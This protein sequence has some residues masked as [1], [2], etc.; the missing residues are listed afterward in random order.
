M[1]KITDAVEALRSV[2]ESTFAG[3]ARL[4]LPYDLP[5]NPDNQLKYGYGIKIDGGQNTA[6]E[7]SCVSYSIKRT[8]TVILC[9]D[10]VAKESD[11]I[12]RDAL[13]MGLFEDLALL[14]AAVV[15][16]VT[17]NG[18]VI[19]CV[20]TDDTGRQEVY[21][22]EQPYIYLEATFDIDYQQ[23]IS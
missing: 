2:V 6:R 14:I 5:A 13:E 10:A 1:S 16:D 18:I 19:S 12:R 9:Q 15:P 17:L 8:M 23:T 7:F 11:P 21:T 3:R 20:Y 4:N 22:K